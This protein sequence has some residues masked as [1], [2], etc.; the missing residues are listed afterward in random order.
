M[1]DEFAITCAGEGST[2]ENSTKHDAVSESSGAPHHAL[3]ESVACSSCRP[4]GLPE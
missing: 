4:P 3:T 2:K 1:L